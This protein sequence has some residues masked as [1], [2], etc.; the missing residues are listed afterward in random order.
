MYRFVQLPN[1]P[2]GKVCTVIAG[3]DC[4]KLFGAR[5]SEMGIRVLSCPKNPHLDPRLASHV[6]LSVFHMG[7][8]SFLLAEYLKGTELEKSLN[9]L[10]AELK[11]SALRQGSRYP[12]DAGLCALSA[13]IRVFHNSSIT[14]REIMSDCKPLV[15]VRQGYAKCTVCLVSEN[16]AISADRGMADALR[17]SGL[18]VLKIRP[19]FIG[20]SGYSEGFIG[21]AAFKASAERL[22]FFG[23]IEAHPDFA[24]ISEF[25]SKH[26]V[27]PV[28]LGEGELLDMGSVIPICEEM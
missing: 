8:N 2:A 14:A 4:A 26:G 15:H 6:D 10:G 28:S 25:L 13:G 1:L 7:Q 18:E 5:L 11:F 9:E 22:V 24:A 19:G 3:E 16:A 23:D 21:G 27:V 17:N 12:A 20:L